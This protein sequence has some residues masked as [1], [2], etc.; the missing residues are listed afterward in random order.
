M[1]VVNDPFFQVLL[2]WERLIG[3]IYFSHGV[4]ENK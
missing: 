3:Y 1:Y 4:N 2:R